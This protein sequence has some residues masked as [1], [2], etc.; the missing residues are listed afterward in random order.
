MP[1]SCFA[2]LALP[3]QPDRSQRCYKLERGKKGD[4]SQPKVQE[5]DLVNQLRHC[6]LAQH[7]VNS[8]TFKYEDL[9]S[10]V[11]HQPAT[12]HHPEASIWAV[13]TDNMTMT[14]TLE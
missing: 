12:G 14:V 11:P 2:A 7:H 8:G 6:G 13:N 1:T 10:A 4:L 5:D 3:S 9:H